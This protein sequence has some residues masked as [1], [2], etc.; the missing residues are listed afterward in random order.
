MTVQA[1]G[2]GWAQ[3]GPS[4]VGRLREAALRD[5]NV[6]VTS[7]VV[8]NLL[9]AVSS[10]ILTRLLAPEVFGISGVIASLQLT[11]ALISDFGFQ[12]FVVRQQD[13]DRTRF[14]DT[15]WTVAILRSIVLTAT[16][17]ILAVP[18][19]HALGRPE[20]AS[21]IAGTSLLF[22]VDGLASTSMITALRNRRIVRLSC[23][24]LFAL[25]MQIAASALLAWTWPS[26]WAI[27]GGMFVGTGLKSALS[28]VA[29]PDARRT[30]A[31]ERETL[32]ALWAFSRYVTGSSIIYLLVTQCD[33]LV[34]ARLMPLDQFGFYVLAGNLASAPLAFAGNYT[35]RVL[36]PAYA[37]LWRGGVTD[38]RA[39]FY[40]RRRLPSLLYALATGG[41]IGSAPL[42]IG[43][44]YHSTYA[45][46]AFYMRI[47]CI[48]SLLAMPSNAA[49]ESLMATGRV[50]A[51]FEANLTKLAWLATMGTGGYLVFGQ[52]GLVF[53]VG[54]IEG[55]A[56]G[57]KWMRMWQVGLLD[58]RQEA[59]F[60]AAG[61]GGVVL[62][63][64]A[65]LALTPLLT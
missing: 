36:L 21:L 38:L 64:G 25:T 8:T 19:A 31:L 13:G 47:L 59:L 20:L 1:S 33:K 49:N 12:G 5:T 22:L 4:L 17:A 52:I 39:Q 3:L 29:F 6:V 50:S 48:S 23:V 32:R 51:Y 35:G 60:M 62:G 37:A 45:D 41:I 27:L 46:T 58:L 44:F 14:L 61:L 30:F 56:L 24:E 7:V 40:A 28:F 2:A 55:A 53:A 16:M 65:D 43:L 54:S 34:L 15:V 11:I 18:L 9:R 63:I 26:Y 10:M 57:W 42:I